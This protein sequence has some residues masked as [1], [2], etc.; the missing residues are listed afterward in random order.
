MRECARIQTF[1]DDYE[2]MQMKLYYLKGSDLLDICISDAVPSDLFASRDAPTSPGTHVPI[3]TSRDAPTSPGTRGHDSRGHDSETA[4]AN[5]QALY[6]RMVER[7]IRRRSQRGSTSGHSRMVRRSG[8][9][10]QVTNWSRC[11]A[12]RQTAGINPGV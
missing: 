10:L 9:D 12:P 2:F 8:R 5:T 6:F 1:P 7:Y 3:V 4:Q 11:G